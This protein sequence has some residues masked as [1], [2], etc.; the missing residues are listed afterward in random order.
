LHGE[1]SD[2]SP[3]LVQISEHEILRDDGRRYVN[4]AVAAGT[5]A[6]LQVWPHMPHVWHIFYPR[7]PESDKA[8]EQIKLFIDRHS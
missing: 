5:D 2:L 8:F 3:I 4:K 7:L 1:L 6:T